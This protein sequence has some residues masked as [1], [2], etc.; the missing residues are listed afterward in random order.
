M[1]SQSTLNKQTTAW[2]G[3]KEG[4]M[5][6]QG[7]NTLGETLYTSHTLYSTITKVTWQGPIVCVTQSHASPL[8]HWGG[9]VAQLVFSFYK[10]PT[11]YS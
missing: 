6:H 9:H 10:L 4:L 7:Y 3:G 5:P 8:V 2:P 11:Q 1:L